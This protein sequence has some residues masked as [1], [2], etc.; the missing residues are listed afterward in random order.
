MDAWGNLNIFTIDA[1]GIDKGGSLGLGG[2]NGQFLT[3]YVFGKIKGGKDASKLDEALQQAH[4][5]V[6]DALSK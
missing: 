6:V 2:E 4:K 5:L 1:A 3:P